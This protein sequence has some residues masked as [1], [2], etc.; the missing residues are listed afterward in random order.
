M[1]GIPY[2]LAMAA[3]VWGC[4]PAPLYTA[5][6]GGRS[7]VQGEIPRDGRGEPVWHLIRPAKASQPMLTQQQV[8]QLASQAGVQTEEGSQMDEPRR[9]DD[10]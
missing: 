7:A 1:R 2:V 8:E 4:A 3:V 6:G 9:A 10:H 5:S